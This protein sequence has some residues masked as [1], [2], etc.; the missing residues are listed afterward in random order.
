MRV[1]RDTTLGSDGGLDRELGTHSGNPDVNSGRWNIGHP[2]PKPISTVVPLIVH[3]DM[4]P[5]V[6]F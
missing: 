3:R 1:G 2:L 4:P 6:A 5:H